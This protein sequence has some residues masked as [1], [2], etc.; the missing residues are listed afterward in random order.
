[1]IN[2]NA[3]ERNNM[4]NSIADITRTENWD[5]VKRTPDAAE[6]KKYHG[7]LKEIA[8]DLY[9]HNIDRMME[10]GNGSSTVAGITLL[11]KHV[12]TLAEELELL[13]EGVSGKSSL[14]PLVQ[15]CEIL[16]GKKDD[17]SSRCKELALITLTH[18]I[19]GITKIR[20]DD[21]HSKVG[22]AKAAVVKL[23]GKVISQKLFDDLIACEQ[24]KV[25]ESKQDPEARQYRPLPR[26][27]LAVKVWGRKAWSDEDTAKRELGLKMGMQL[28]NTML[29]KIDIAEVHNR[30]VSKHTFKNLELNEEYQDEVQAIIEQGASQVSLDMPNISSIRQWEGPKRFGKPLV[31]NIKYNSLKD[32]AEK[33]IFRM[34]KELHSRE[35]MPEVYQCLDIIEATEWT[36]DVEMVEILKQCID[37][38]IEIPGINSKV[39]VAPKPPSLYAFKKETSEDWTEKFTEDDYNM[40]EFDQA[41]DDYRKQNP[42]AFEGKANRAL[43]REW[44][45]SHKKSQANFSKCA[46]GRRSIETAESLQE[47]DKLYFAHNLCTR[48]RVYPIATTINPQLNDV[49]KGLLKFAEGDEVSDESAE[50]LKINIANNWAEDVEIE[51]SD[52][53][54][55]AEMEFLRQFV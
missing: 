3:Q 14:K 32:D 42:N 44:H 2:T 6:I 38:G 54:A 21:N 20:K 9:K 33:S 4:R 28:V 17:F 47:Y 10:T 39:V 27:E 23:I 12:W 1:M 11:K 35:S 55:L 8:T 46:A 29:E 13:L 49:S 18:V 48:G 41:C 34:D 5:G 26:K 40:D 45:K 30:R 43:I 36:V 19:N 37:Q 22:I 51:L 52:E 24:R 15:Y 25:W 16:P 7:K 31:R 50:W 53:E